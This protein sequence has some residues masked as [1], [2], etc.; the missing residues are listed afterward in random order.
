GCAQWR[1]LA[2]HMPGR[3]S[4]QCRERWCSYLD[5]SLKRSIWS[6]EE[7]AVILSAQ[8][9]LGNRWSRIAAL[10]PGRTENA[11]KLRWKS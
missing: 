4:K 5:P 8:A 9:R 10:L 7:D 2:Q 1:D 3:T 11:V 6:G